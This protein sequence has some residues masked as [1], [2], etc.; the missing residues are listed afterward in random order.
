MTSGNLLR[1]LEGHAGPVDAVT[2][3][4][5]G[6]LI[7]SKSHDG[8]IRLWNSETGKTA[9]VIPEP[10]NARLW[11]P[12]LA[13]CSKSP[14]LA[15]VGSS[16]GTPEDERGRL[17]H[18]WE[19]DLSVLLGQPATPAVTYTSAKVVL[20]GDS[21]VGKTGL[22]WR[23]AHGEFKEH[24]STHGQQFWPLTQLDQTRKDGAQCE[25]VLWDL[26]GQPD[27]RLIHALFLDDADLALV[28]FDPTDSRDPLHGVEFWLKQLGGQRAVATVADRGADEAAPSAR[29]AFPKI[30][31][32]ARCDRGDA[33]LTRE[34]LEAFCRQ[35]GIRA[36]HT[37]SASKGDGVEELIARMKELIQWEEKP[38]TVTTE[39]FK[40][41][42]DHVLALKEDSRCQ[43]VIVTPTELRRRLEAMDSDWQFTDAELLTAVG[44][45][46]NH[47]YVTRL[48]TSQ[49]EP[50]ILLA[51]ELLN[52]V[53]ASFVLE[54]RRNDRGLGALEEK[55]LLKGEYSFPELANLPAAERD[56]LL[57]SATILFLKHNVCF[58]E[59][60]PLTSIAY[61]VFPELI[62]L[63]K[64]AIEDDQAVE[65]GVA[66]S[67]SGSV[68]NVYA[69]MVVLLGYTQT[70][71]RRNQWRNHARY[72]VG[73][74][75]LCG[76][77]QESER[78]GELDFVLSFGRTVGAPIRTLFQSLFESF[79]SGRN[80][81]VLRYE[82]ALCPDG[83]PLERAVVRE[84]TKR[85]LDFAFC[86][87]DGKRLSLPKADQPIQL[88][89][90]QAT[91]VE[92]ERHA[93][94]RRK[95]FEEALFRVKALVVEQRIKVPDCFISYS[96]GDLNRTSSGVAT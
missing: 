21:G 9:A 86:P 65:D 5:D 42:K 27:Y 35:R 18:L 48:K 32:A 16:S 3:S 6:R 90:Q 73:N 2:F 14:L 80:L 63:K 54:A 47:G 81:T 84:R 41:I 58:R 49:G 69:S 71:T 38:A 85:G 51:P 23:L 40:R 10:T 88:T 66:Y 26:A 95:R 1:T 30:L 25:A 53:A 79:L 72:E 56:I 89:R 77:R 92:M 59:T 33:R 60:D 24:T 57:D 70:F 64:P 52:N 43:E 82:A 94:E 37:T 17:I 15:S 19:L 93:T 45:L 83:H 96:W 61:L 44:H 39:T 68:E 29:D 36:Y 55:R 20:V 11:L 4:T 62:N 50:R 74:G 34:D 7:A 87:E 46:A 12:G 67:V 78:D 76:L 22:G 75:L 28:L 8:T 31:V 13:F 91:D